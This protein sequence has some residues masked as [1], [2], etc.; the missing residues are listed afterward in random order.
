MAESVRTSRPAPLRRDAVLEAVTFAAERLLLAQ[1]WH[2]AIDEVLARFGIAAAVSRATVVS[3]TADPSGDLVA[4]GAAEW[5]A[6]G[7][8]TMVDHP[9]L[10]ESPWSPGFDRWVDAMTAGQPIVGD[11]ATFPKSEQEEFELQGIRS[12]AYYPV[13]V[14]G[15]WWGCIGFEDCDGPRS[16]SLTDLDGARTAAALLGAAIA[17]QRQDARLRDAET[18]YRG[19]VE[20][21]PA[22]TYLDVSYPDTVRMAFLSPQIEVLLGYPAQG[23]L[24]EPDSWFDL[25]HPDDQERIDEAARRSG[26]GGDPFD[27]EYRMRHADGHWVWVHDTSTPVPNDDGSEVVYFQGFLTDISARKQAEAARIEAEHRYR[28]MVEAL[29]AVT[30][31]DEPLEG[32]DNSANMPFVSPQVEQ[33]LGYPPHRFLEDNRFWFEI[34]H[35]DDYARMRE[36]GELSVSNLDEVTQEYRM[37]HANGHWVWV[38]D[39]SRP[40]FGGDGELLFFQGFLVD[41]S[42]RH[43]AEERLREAEERFRVLVEQMPA[44]VYTESL[45]IGTSRATGIDYVSEHATRMLGYPPSWWSRGVD[46]WSE[47]IHSDDIEAVSAATARA[48]ATGLPY[49]LDYRMVAA[50]GRTVWVHE[51]SVLIRDSN[52]EPAYWQGIILDVTERVQAVE[53]I[54][55]A[56]ERFRQIVEHTPVITY[57]EA[58][59]ENGY[60]QDSVMYYVSPQIERILGYPMQRWAEP[61]FWASATHPD[62]LAIIEADTLRATATGGAYRSEYRMIAADG[63]TVW[64]HDEAMLIRDLDGAPVSWQGVMVDVTERREAEEQ[65]QRA[66]GR[67]QALIDHIPAVVYREAP[68]ASPEKFYL[69]SQVEQMFGVTADEWT[70]TPDFW[71]DHIHPDDRDRVLAFDMEVDR[72]HA[73]YS[74]EYRFRRGDGTYIWVQDEA[75]FLQ[76]DPH[77]EGSWQGLLFDI[78]ARKEAEE[79]LRASELVHSATVEH[80][81]AIVYRETPDGEQSEIDLYISPQVEQIL[82]YTPEEW[83]DSHEE[84]WASHIHPDDL[85]EVLVANNAADRTRQPYA[86][87]YRF[88]HRDGTYRWVHDEATFVADERGGWWQGF[89]IDITARKEAEEQLREAEEKFRLIV[90]RGPAVI[91]QQEFDVKEPS[92]SRTTYI[93]PQQGAMFGYTAEEVLADPTLWSRTLHPDDRDRVL[94]AD[95]SSNRDANEAFSLEYRMIA[96]DGRIVWVEDTSLLVQLEGRPP[97]WQGFLIDITERK[98]AEEQLAHAL[99][100]ER[101]AAQRL[102]ALDEMKNTFLQAVSHDLRTPL[103]AILGLAITLERGDVHLDED[104]A[105]D[106]ARRIAGNARRLDRLVTNLLD[107]DRLA[108]GIVAPNLLPTDVGSVVRR[109]LAESDL[110]PDARLHTDIQPVMVR[111]DGAKVERIVENLLA[112]TVRHT[113]DTSTIWV[114]LAPTEEGALLAVEDDGAGVPEDLRDTI[115]EPFRQGPDAPRHSPGVGV[116]L[117][118]VRR[119]AELHG[120]RAWVEE[121]EG[122]GASFRV[123]LPF[124]PPANVV[125]TLGPIGDI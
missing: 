32:D 9:G 55:I 108:R 15:D 97:F 72:T 117:T 7:V 105:K 49:S 62:D 69:S 35:P 124:E 23:F 47:V 101:D 38:Q 41:V 52:G 120:G 89:I 85:T 113:P 77:H 54:R 90:E 115:F 92:I 60:E 58:P 91:Y 42:M 29:P 30:Y 86:S 125:A 82:G 100:V 45:E 16:W 21:I 93:S 84:F 119:F 73:A 96:K 28:T 37:R 83:T 27:E 114:R 8:P 76:P 43:E 2:D 1:D 26:N 103:A 75:A 121:R 102:R 59:H 12:L 68:D 19:V 112:N 57:Q 5:C 50:D 13:T 111:A 46:R 123:L 81:P 25:V 44:M 79:Q 18:R 31:I 36:A 106:L 40:V 3:S 80:L 104:D 6:P 17:R 34:M 66:Q 88:R 63:R 20:R 99:A 39:T 71:A 109:V 94:A 107:L 87:D 110:I 98:Q 118:L 61:G 65:L 33:I 64:F 78:T 11:V 10:Q 22:V 70:W 122:G 74:L 56:E 48:N 4:T 24:D 51:E 14:E 67:L 53:R 95:V 116:G